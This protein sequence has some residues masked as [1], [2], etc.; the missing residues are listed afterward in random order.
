MRLPDV[1]VRM[2]ILCPQVR[3]AGIGAIRIRA[4]KRHDPQPV[5]PSY[6]HPTVPSYFFLFDTTSSATES[7]DLC[8]SNLVDERSHDTTR[9]L[10]TKG[11]RSDVEYA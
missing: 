7:P 4:D 5:H 10:D 9:G 3:D 1:S 2:F 11:K 8:F 6:S